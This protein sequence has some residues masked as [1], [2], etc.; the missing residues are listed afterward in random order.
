MSRTLVFEGAGA[1]TQVSDSRWRHDMHTLYA[2][3]YAVVKNIYATSWHNV[4]INIGTLSATAGPLQGEAWGVF[5]ER[6][7]TRP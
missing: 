7:Q 4:L 3:T 2:L 1:V 5:C 6:S